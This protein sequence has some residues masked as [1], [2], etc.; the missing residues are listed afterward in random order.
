MSSDLMVKDEKAEL[1]MDGKRVENDY[2]FTAADTKMEVE[3]VFTFDA[4]KLG[5]KQLVTFEELYDITNPDEP[6][7][8]TEHKDIE[9]EG[10]TVLITERI[11]KIHTN[12]ASKDGEKVI[13]A[14]KEVTIVDT[15]T[16]DGLKKGIKY[17][18]KGWQM[19]SEERRVGKECT[20][21][22]RSRWSPYH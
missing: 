10:Q 11:I 21:W 13:E 19:R 8:V 2:I 14:G 4:S 1:L 18:L 5:G 6:V 12:A 16:L 7:K 9:D 22:C 20:S 15:V 3:I 17:Q